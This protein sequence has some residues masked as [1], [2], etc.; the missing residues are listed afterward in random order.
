MRLEGSFVATITPF[1]NGKINEEKLRELVRFQFENGTDGIV[2]CGTTGESPALADEEKARVIEIVVDESRGKG[3]VVAGTGTN[4]TE[5]TIVATRR[6]KELGADAALVLTPYY[7]KPSQEGLFRHFEA[8]LKAVD[9]P[10]V[11]YIVPG[12]TSVNMMPETVQRLAEF[13]NIVAVKEASGDLVQA[14]EIINRCGDKIKVLS[15]D[16]PLF[17]PMLAI[18]GHGIVSVTA[19]ILPAQVKAI[20]QAFKANDNLKVMALHQE[21]MSINRALFFET[22]PGPVKTAMNMLGKNVGDLRLPL[23]AMSDENAEKLR[24]VLQTYKLI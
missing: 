3:M 10:I 7:N 23:A 19:N 18:G 24:A 5:K 14:T 17:A 4:N 15:G 20:Y 11:I 12:R 21:M 22:N 9:L 13:D 6:A 1:K 2:P 16:D 8:I